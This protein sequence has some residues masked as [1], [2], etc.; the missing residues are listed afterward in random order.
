MPKVVKYFLRLNSTTFPQHNKEKN[1]KYYILYNPLAGHGAHNEINGEL[2]SKLGGECVECNVTEIKDY[3][4]FVASLSADDVIV[5][6]GG[7]GTLNRFINAVDTDNITNDV[8]YYAS[9]SGN[10]FLHDVGKEPGCAP[11]KINQYLKNLPTVTVKGKTYRFINGVGYGI[12]GYCCEVGDKLKAEGKAVNYTSIAIKGLLFHFK[13]KNAKVVADGKEYSFKKTW[14]APTML[15]RFY[16]GGMMPTPEQSRLGDDSVSFMAFHGT[17]K[18]KTLM[19][20][21]SLFKGEHTKHEKKVELR[22]GKH[23]TVEFDSP[24]PLQIDGETIKGVKKFS[25]YYQD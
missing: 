4:K 18:F 9:G 19:I 1:M 20:F 3:N 25:F 10:D 12:D 15:G 16:G 8:L 7:D 22:S 23:I 24:R 14:I 11:F 6:S 2:Q 21:P 5:L 17:G 13:P